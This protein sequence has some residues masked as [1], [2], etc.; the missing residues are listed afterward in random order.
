MSNQYQ[1]SNKGA[2]VRT[3]RILLK[4]NGNTNGAVT[5]FY[6]AASC[7]EDRDAMFMLGGFWSRQWGDLEKSEQNLQRALKWYLKAV[8]KGCTF[9]QQALDKINHKLSRQQ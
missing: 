1:P 3:T 2:S 4:Q 5:A 7:H 9:S 6:I 8:S